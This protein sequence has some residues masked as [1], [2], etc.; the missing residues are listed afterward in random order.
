MKTT[1][2]PTSILSTLESSSYWLK[3]RQEQLENMLFILNLTVGSEKAKHEAAEVCGRL[4]I[5]YKE[6]ADKCKLI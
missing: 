5:L 3:E 2:T 6:K 4:A 1:G